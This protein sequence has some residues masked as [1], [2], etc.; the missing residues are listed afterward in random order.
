MKIFE[1]TFA[2]LGLAAAVAIAFGAFWHIYTLA[3]C[4]AMVWT[5]R[6]ERTNK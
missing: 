5:I 1:I 3:A 2:T 6:K 4:G